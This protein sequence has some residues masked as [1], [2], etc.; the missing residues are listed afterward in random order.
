MYMQIKDLQRSVGD[1]YANKG[2]MV[3]RTWVRGRQGAFRC[4]PAA[5]QKMA[6]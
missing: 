4:G 3:T 5:L 2:L 1:R 6:S